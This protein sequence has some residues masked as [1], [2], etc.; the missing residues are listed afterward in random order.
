[1]TPSR[2]IRKFLQNPLSVV[3]SLILLAFVIVAILAP[4]LA[5]PEGVRGWKNPY[6][7]P[8]DGFVAVP[9]LPSEKHPMGTTEGQYD[10]YY[11]IV[12]GTRT[13]FQVGIITTAVT[14][15][16][17]LFVGSVAAYYGGWVDEV[18]MR[19]VEVFQAFPFLL[20]AIT[21]AAVLQARLGRGPAHGV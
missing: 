12:W 6:I 4:V 21:M 13:A 8:R 11:G 9:A 14:L 15:V 17:G 20:A 5:P 19:I 10:I 18:L 16:I 2:F 1:M 3:G 7:I